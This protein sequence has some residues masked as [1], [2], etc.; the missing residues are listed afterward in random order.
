MSERLRADPPTKARISD[1]TDDGCFAQRIAPARRHP[2]L[3]SPSIPH[4]F[5]RSSAGEPRRPRMRQGRRMDIEEWLGTGK[6]GIAHRDLALRAGFS[7]PTVAKAAR[8]GRINVIR[9]ILGESSRRSRRPRQG[10]VCGRS[11]RVR[12][13][14]A[15]SRVVAP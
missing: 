3:P 8:D 6:V 1:R 5:R 12:V 14:G 10:G 13:G 7:A 11:R 9:Q 4:C 2:L 15:V